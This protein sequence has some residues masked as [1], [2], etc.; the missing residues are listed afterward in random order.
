MTEFSY[1]TDIQTRYRDIDGMG[2][3]N[4]AVYVTYLESARQGYY[5]DVIGERL[6]QVDTVVARLEIDY[7]AS[8]ELEQ[9]VEVLIAIEQLG[10]SSIGMRYEIRADDEI[11]ARAET[12]QVV[13]DG[14]TGSSMRIPDKWRAK[15]ESNRETASE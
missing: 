8:I 14:D 15:I 9:Q 2:H 1:S 3:V 11:A 10:N 4:N 13:I 5:R 7:E 12:T 6:D